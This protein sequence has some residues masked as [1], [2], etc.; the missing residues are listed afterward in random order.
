MEVER[1]STFQFNGVSSS[2]YS[3]L[4]V[5]DIGRR[6][7]AKEQIDTYVIPYRDGSLHVHSGK[8]YSYQRQMLLGV[9]NKTQ[10]AAIAAW[11]TGSGRLITSDDAGGYFNASVVSALDVTGLSRKF[12]SFKGHSSVSRS[13]I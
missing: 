3:S 1:L 5:S 2:A 9:K 8:Y 7:R 6:Q 12:D 4:V 13:S 11:L 10:R